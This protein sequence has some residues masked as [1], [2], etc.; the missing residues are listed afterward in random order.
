VV[1]CQFALG[2]GFFGGLVVGAEPA[3]FALGFFGGALVVQVYQAL[4]EFFFGLL[5]FFGFFGPG[6][7]G[8]GVAD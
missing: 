3:D 5:L 2:G 8:A 6:G 1:C 4:E 7:G